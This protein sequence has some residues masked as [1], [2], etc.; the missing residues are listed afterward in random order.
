MSLH[1]KYIQNTFIWLHLFPFYQPVLLSKAMT[2]A[3]SAE[4]NY[5]AENHVTWINYQYLKNGC[6]KGR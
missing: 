4:I 6:I 3:L 1:I 5:R 2:L